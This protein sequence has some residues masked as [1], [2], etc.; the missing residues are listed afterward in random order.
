MKKLFILIMSLLV[1]GMVTP[2][3]AEGGIPKGAQEYADQFFLEEVKKHLKPSLAKDYNLIPYSENIT[4]GPLHPTYTLTR[5]FVKGKTRG[6][7]GIIRTEEYISV[8]YQDDIPVNVIGTYEKEPGE[9]EFSTFGY[10]PDLARE[11]DQL[12]A[13]EWVLNEAPQHTWYLYN[14]KTVKPLTQ[15]TQGLMA[16]EKS[17]KEYQ[18]IVIERYKDVDT[19]PL[20]G[21]IGLYMIL[22]VLCAAVLT[23]FIYDRKLK[24]KQGN[25]KNQHTR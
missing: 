1:I 10:G 24:R 4:F 11:L 9:F 8:V 6:A 12:K 21:R 18:Q 3:S 19:N 7:D 25:D 5:N 23:L 16:E 20:L 13:G 14:G 2:V 22:G 17:V 15:Q